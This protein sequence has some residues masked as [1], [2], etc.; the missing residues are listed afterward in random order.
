MI[1]QLNFPGRGAAPV[2]LTYV[3]VSA[4]LLAGYGMWRR[5]ETARAV[6]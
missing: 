5:R 1:V 6:A 3:L 2:V 4:L